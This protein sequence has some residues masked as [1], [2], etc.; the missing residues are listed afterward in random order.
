MFQLVTPRHAYQVRAVYGRRIGVCGYTSVLEDRQ[1]D[2]YLL[3]CYLV[4]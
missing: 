4:Y 1:T 2:V 3:D